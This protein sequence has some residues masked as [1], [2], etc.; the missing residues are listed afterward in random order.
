[1]IGNDV[2]VLSIALRGIEER[3]TTPRRRFL[4]YKGRF[5]EVYC[6]RDAKGKR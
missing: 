1:M 4:H 2:P 5:L 6:G 3:R